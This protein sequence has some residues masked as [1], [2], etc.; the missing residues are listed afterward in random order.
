MPTPGRPNTHSPPRVS[1]RAMHRTV[2]RSPA[3]EVRACR[4]PTALR[5]DPSVAQGLD[6]LRAPERRMCLP[7]HANPE[8]AIL[9]LSKAAKRPFHGDL[10]VTLRI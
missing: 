2:R 4:R 7:R 1:A 5:P 8:T 3:P 9:G 10:L 6:R